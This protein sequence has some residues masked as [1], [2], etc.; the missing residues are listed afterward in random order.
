MTTD[1]PFTMEEL[2]SALSKGKRDTAPG[3]DAITYS[4]LR[5]MGG[6]AKQGAI[7]SPFLFNV[8]MEL[9]QGV[10]VFIY[11]DDVCIIN[12]SPQRQL[13]KMQEASQNLEDKCTQLGLKINRNKTKAMITAKELEERAL[14]L[15]FF[16]VDRD[17]KHQVIG[18]VLFMLKDLAPWE[19]KRM[20]RR[21][22]EREVS[23]SPR[24]LGQLEV[25]LCYNN[26]LERLTVTV[27]SAKQLKVDE[28]IRQDKN[29]FQA[30][31]ALMQQTKMNKTKKTA[32]V[33]GTDSPSFNESFNFKVAPDALD[34]TAVCIHITAGKKSGIHHLTFQSL[35][36]RTFSV[37]SQG[38]LPD[39]NIKIVSVKIFDFKVLNIKYLK[40][41]GAL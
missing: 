32:V 14:K 23:L 18:H 27:G 5:P 34:T 31:V 36:Y 25:S 12:A 30:R 41:L 39:V 19:G 7:L 4:M 22:L 37:I 38:I 35:F 21:D 20:L 10:E 6:P 26:N 17:K 11:A 13:Q 8:L 2:N 15:T 29:E 3:A 16:D 40:Y 33:K 9:P 24:D 28:D 1:T